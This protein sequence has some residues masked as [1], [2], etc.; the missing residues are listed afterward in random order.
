MNYFFVTSGINCPYGLVSIE[1]RLKQTHETAVNIKSKVPD[2]IILLLEGG[3]DPLRL[4]QRSYLL[5]EFDD[6]IDYV[7]HPTI[8][9]AH[10]QNVN[11]LYVKGPCESLMMSETLKLIY[12]ESNDRIFKISGRHLLSDRF[13]IEKHNVKGKYVFL[14]QPGV[15]YY[16]GTINYIDTPFQYKTRLY[17]ICGS[18]IEQ[19]REDFSNI[20]GGIISSYS[21]NSF[22]DIEHATFRTIDPELVHTLDPIGLTGIQAETNGVVDE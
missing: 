7:N 11:S 19:A 4:E 5:E 15:K 2:S 12:P 8:K 6:I 21:N 3:K 10:D 18:M 9:F 13:D 17:S 16:G 1:D 22:I 20:F 14:K